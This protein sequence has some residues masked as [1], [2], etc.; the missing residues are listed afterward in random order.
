MHLN[1]REHQLKIIIMH[2]HR[3]LCRKWQ[4]SPALLPGKSHGQRSLI[5]YSPWGRK[6]SDTTEWLHFTSLHVPGSDCYRLFPQTARFSTLP[7]IHALCD[8]TLELWSQSG[9]YLLPLGIWVCFVTYFTPQT[10]RGAVTCRL[11]A[12]TS[13]LTLGSPLPPGEQAQVTGQKMNEHVK[14]RAVLAKAENVR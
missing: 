2:I 13:V 11:W 1:L 8:V 3:L 12:S 6:E 9:V 4:S 7:H 14:W 10:A 5:G